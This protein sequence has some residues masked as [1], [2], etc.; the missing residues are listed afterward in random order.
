MHTQMPSLRNSFRPP[1][2]P[3]EGSTAVLVCMALLH[4]Q[5]I[6]CSRKR[7]ARLMREMKLCARRPRHR[8]HTTISDRSR[9]QSLPIGFSATLRQLVLTRNG[10]A[11]SRR[12]GP[13]VGWLSLAVVLDL[14]SRKAGASGRWRPIRMRRSLRRP[15]A[16]PGFLGD[17]ILAC[18]SILTGDHTI[19]VMR[20]EPC[21]QKGR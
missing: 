6:S 7:V 15:C 2:T 19:P 14:F 12:S 11:I 21:L 20:I 10:L 9:H 17:Q 1:I 8:T 16:W 13:D 4:E 5:G 3:I 18:F